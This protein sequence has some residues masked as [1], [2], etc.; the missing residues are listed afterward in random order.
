MQLLFLGII[1]IFALIFI[2]AGYGAV[3]ALGLFISVV[4]Y[5]IDYS[6]AIFS[7]IIFFIIATITF[8]VRS[9]DNNNGE[10]HMTNTLGCMIFSPI[11]CVLLG[12]L[13]FLS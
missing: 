13:Q 7:F 4:L 2:P 8:T 9:F 6:T 3:Y 1:I 5:L 12:F 11:G 10:F